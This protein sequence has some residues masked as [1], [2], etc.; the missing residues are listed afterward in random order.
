[1]IINL[2][3]AKTFLQKNWSKS[4]QFSNYFE[5]FE[6]VY[7]NKR[8]KFQDNPEPSYFDELKVRIEDKL[9]EFKIEGQIINILKGP[10]VDTFELELGTGVKVSKVNSFIPDL[11]LALKGAPI[12]IVYPMKGKSTI[13]IEVPRSLEN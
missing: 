3:F 2:F 13:G 8:T 5:L 1:M 9:S 10:V 11:S 7:K 6:K 12:R 4:V